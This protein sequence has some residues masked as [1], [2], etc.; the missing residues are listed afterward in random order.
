MTLYYFLLISQLNPRSE[1]SLTFARIYDC[2]LQG[3]I[4]MK[5]IKD[6]RICDKNVHGGCHYRWHS[7]RL[8]SPAVDII[9]AT[10]AINWR[11]DISVCRRYAMRRG[12]SLLP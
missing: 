11:I 9:E 1:N 7:G 10:S 12:L 4:N 8:Y 2:R 5:H 6:Q 3:I